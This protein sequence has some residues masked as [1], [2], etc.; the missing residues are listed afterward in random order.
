MKTL[1][2]GLGNP[3]LSDDGVGIKVAHEVA[4]QF[5][6]PQ[7]TVAETSAAGLSLLDSIVGYDKV[8]IIDAIQ[9]KKGQAGQIYR[10]KSEDFSFAKRFSSPH[11]IN[12]V[13]ALEL[14][15]ML[16]LAM[17]QKITIFAIE[18]KDIASFSE[19]CTPEVERAIPEAVKMVLQELVG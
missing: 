5:N 9:T 10:M 11:Q 8:I 17:P 18:A 14:G 19:K 3:I 15:K 6:S 1:V 12:L 2:L 13:T 7:V 16:G 4:N